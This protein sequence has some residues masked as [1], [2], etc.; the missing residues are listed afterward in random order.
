MNQL[1]YFGIALLAMLL[2][3]SVSLVMGQAFSHTAF[4]SVMAIGYGLATC[5]LIILQGHPPAISG[6]KWLCGFAIGS[7]QSASFYLEMAGLLKIGAHQTAAIMAFV[8]VIA[9]LFQYQ[10]SA[11]SWRNSAIAIAAF[12]A[13]GALSVMAHPVWPKSWNSGYGLV[14]MAAVALAAFFYGNHYVL[15]KHII[16][17]VSLAI[18]SL[19]TQTIWITPA[20][21]FLTRPLPLDF[22][23]GVFFGLLILAV[24]MAAAQFCLNKA[25]QAIAAFPMTLI[26]AIEPFVSSLFLW[27]KGR[28]L[29]PFIGIAAGLLLIALCL[30]RPWV[31][32]GRK[33]AILPLIPRK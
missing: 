14:L 10:K 1:A 12:C 4:A 20:A 3:T 29:P 2:N 32:R 23:S 15:K 9:F 27:I 30:A 16:D 13:L 25:Q 18:I 11:F 21:L 8:V 5:L 22:H 28:S 7:L 19:L 33:P 26:F 31:I 6:K 24:L 17:P